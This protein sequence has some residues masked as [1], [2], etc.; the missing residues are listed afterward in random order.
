MLGLRTTLALFLAASLVIGCADGGGGVDA[1]SQDDG[2]T[3]PRDSG[4]RD[5]GAPACPAGQHRCG[6]GCIDDLPNE[7]E[8]GCRYGCGEPCPTPTGGEAACDES[9][10]CTVACPPPYHREGDECVCRARTCEEL[11]FECG[12]PDDGCGGA[13]DCG[14][15]SGDAMCIDGRCACAPDDREPNDG[16]LSVATIGGTLTDSPASS[17]TFE[18]FNI[19]SPDDEDWFRIAVDDVLDC[20][21]ST[22]P[23]ITVTLDQIPAGSDF[24]LSVWYVCSSGGGERC[25]QERPCSGAASGQTSEQVSFTTQCSRI[26]EDGW[27]WIRVTARRWGGS[28]APYSLHVNVD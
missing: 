24:D 14:S 13:L 17:V 3:P 16:M 6:A 26:N 5:S 12:A 23:D 10:R 9:G 2:G 20:C 15:C 7:P 21:T 28:C 8:N 11:G 4:P 27:L 22:N 19:H 18:S 1:G 25:T